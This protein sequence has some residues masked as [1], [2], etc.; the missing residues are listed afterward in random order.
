MS[1]TA[2]LGFLTVVLVILSSTRKL[3][4]FS[5]EKI[6]LRNR[7]RNLKTSWDLRFVLGLQKYHRYFGMSALL[8]A[9]L[10]ASLAFARLGAPSLT[11]STLVIL[12][13][14]Q[15]VTGYLQEKGKGSIRM[16]KAIH[17]FVPYLLFILIILHII[18][19]TQSL[20]SLGIFG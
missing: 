5:L 6:I 8:V 12:L 7:S 2:F 11:G 18:F 14:I 19:N 16:A 1:F 13:I 17:E 15:G 9:I 3:V 4:A 10:H 20:G